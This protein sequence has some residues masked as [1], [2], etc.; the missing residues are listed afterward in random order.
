M[1]GWCGLTFVSGGGGG[2]TKLGGSVVFTFV[3]GGGAGNT[4]PGGDVFCC[5][6]TFVSCVTATGG[7]GTPASACPAGTG[8]LSAS[9]GGPAFHGGWIGCI[10]PGTEA[11][12][13]TPAG[14]TGK[15]GQPGV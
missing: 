13:S 3:S 1:F 4:K 6:L 8:F 10:T 5:S 12:D 15:D 11:V 2:I 14:L 7:F 9:V